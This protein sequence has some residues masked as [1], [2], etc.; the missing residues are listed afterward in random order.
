MI[1]IVLYVLHVDVLFLICLI[2]L[3]KAPILWDFY[4]VQYDLFLVIWYPIV[5]M[6][7]LLDIYIAWI[8][9]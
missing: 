7:L 2:I 6:L 1:D 4:I 8:F 3:K 5:L 9:N